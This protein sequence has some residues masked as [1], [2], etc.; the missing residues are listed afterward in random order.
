MK[1]NGDF[2][3]ITAHNYYRPYLCD[4]HE[5]IKGSVVMPKLRIFTRLSPLIFIYFNENR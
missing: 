3:V 1:G 4:V 2:T 5:K